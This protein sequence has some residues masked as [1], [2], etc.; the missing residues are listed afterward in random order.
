MAHEYPLEGRPPMMTHLYKMDDTMIAAG[1]GAV[2]RITA[3]CRLDAAAIAQVTTAMHQMA[4]AGYR[5][6]AVASA[7]AGPVLPGKQ[8][9]FDWQLEGLIGLYDPPKAGIDTAFVQLYAAGIH[10]K[11]ITGDYAATALN[12]AAQTGMTEAT[13]YCTGDTVMQLSQEALQ[14][15]VQRV[16]IFARMF[17]EAKL[18]VIDALKANGEIVGMTGD[19]V[20]DGPALKSANIGIAMGQKGTEIARQSADLVLTDDNL[21]KVVEAIA[22]G[23]KIFSNLKKAV[24][25]IISIHIPIILT[26]SLPLLL[27]WTYPNIFTPI[28][29]IFLELIMGPTCSVFFEREPAAPGLMQQPPRNRTASMF[30]GSELL[31]SIAQGLGI[32]L[33]VLAVYY[34]YMQQGYSIELTRTMVFTTLLCSNILLTFINRSFTRSLFHTMRYRNNLVPYVL[35]ASLLFMI[36]ILFVPPV[37]SVFRLAPVSAMQFMIAAGAAMA[38]TLWFE[39]YKIQRRPRH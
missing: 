33:A 31:V 5:V 22:Y 16:H 17:P 12:I 30:A 1:K 4:A 10:I 8:D 14:E 25:Y 24:R 34:Y 21:L 36:A 28:H 38:G 29:V 39:L 13:E 20:N 27:G 18:R 15:T 23:R 26:A 9:D 7:V 37:R 19:G 32:T 2:E 6:L 35:G 3:V 11:M